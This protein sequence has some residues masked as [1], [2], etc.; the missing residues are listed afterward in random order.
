MNPAMTLD[1][2]T[3]APAANV[4]TRFFLKIVDLKL[5]TEHEPA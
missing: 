2:E 4:W 1:E 3:A 5:G